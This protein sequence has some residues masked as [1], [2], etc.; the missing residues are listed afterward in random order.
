MLAVASFLLKVYD[1]FVVDFI[2]R[3]GMVR[4]N[5]ESVMQECVTKGPDGK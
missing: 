3:I 4:Q 5:V 1:V 2:P